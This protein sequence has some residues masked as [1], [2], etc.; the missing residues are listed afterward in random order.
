M[1]GLKS[2]ILW[3][4]VTVILFS[5]SN[6]SILLARRIRGTSM[7]DEFL[8]KGDKVINEIV[9]GIMSSPRGAKLIKDIRK[10][11]EEY[12]T[13]DEGYVFSLPLEIDGIM[14]PAGHGY[15]YQTYIVFR[16]KDN[17]GRSFISISPE[18]DLEAEGFAEDPSCKDRHK[19]IIRCVIQALK[20]LG[21]RIEKERVRNISD[22]YWYNYYYLPDN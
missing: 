13:P 22:P 4:F 10:K 18:G 2:Q 3:V 1:E 5:L 14:A 8:E 7:V 11:L 19:V 12:Q 21:L 9:R 15:E 6:S 16:K 20:S 17:L